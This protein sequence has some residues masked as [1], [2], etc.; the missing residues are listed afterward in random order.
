[1]G[2]DQKKDEE[3]RRASTP[4]PVLNKAWKP[5]KDKKF[6]FPDATIPYSSG[7]G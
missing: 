7:I 3:C 2:A 5:L 4:L 1:M 6:F